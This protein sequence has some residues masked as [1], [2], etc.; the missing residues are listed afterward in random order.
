[1]QDP[2][3]LVSGSGPGAAVRD[4]SVR[5]WNVACFGLPPCAA[6]GAR[7]S[8]PRNL[9]IYQNLTVQ[10][11]FFYQSTSSCREF[12]TPKFGYF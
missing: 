10:K 3:N 7:P 2:I 1:M 8:S 5:V 4:G 12:S 6:L 9:T 11:Q